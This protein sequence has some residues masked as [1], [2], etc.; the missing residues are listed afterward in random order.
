MRPKQYGNFPVKHFIMI[1]FTDSKFL[2]EYD[3]FCQKLN[4][5]SPSDFYEGLLQKPS[6]LHM[7]VL[8]MD[9]QN[10]ESKI[11]EICNIMKEL[12][13]EIKKLSEG[14]IIYSFD[15]YE[16]FDSFR[17]A[18]V[19]FAK[20][21]EDENKYKLNQII[22]LI[23]KKLLERGIISKNDFN[24]LH[25]DQ[26]GPDSNPFY[27]IQLH[28]TL[29]NTTFL[30]KIL[31]KSHK[32]PVK[33]LDATNIHRCVQGIKFPDCPLNKIDFCVL[34]EDKHTGKYEVIQ[35]FDLI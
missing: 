4:S 35:S 20:M 18:R 26:E 25:I 7:S 27:K 9:L 29:L 19:M 1:P 17:K 24:E 31:K 10:D 33:N 3:K 14:K 28:L 16:A 8:I 32:P 15:G 13:E 6:K 5:E 12:Q 2:E 21:K 34:R 23:I 30:N 11:S 22:D